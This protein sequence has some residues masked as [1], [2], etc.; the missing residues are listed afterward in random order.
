MLHSYV[1]LLYTYTPYTTFS[2]FLLLYSPFWA[3][4]LHKW[5]TNGF[6]YTQY[7]MSP[8]NGIGLILCLA[9]LAVGDPQDGKLHVEMRAAGLALP[10]VVPWQKVWPHHSSTFKLG[11]TNG[12]AMQRKN[13]ACLT[14]GDCIDI[15]VTNL[16]SSILLICV[17]MLMCVLESSESLC[18]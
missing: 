3:P 15:M 9:L 1:H 4:L 17:V 7:S 2:P 14:P 18:R 12:I 13:S 11:A 8:R 10:R 5:C 6:F 16:V